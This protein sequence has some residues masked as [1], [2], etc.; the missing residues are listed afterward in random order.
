MII[1]QGVEGYDNR[2]F[3]SYTNKTEFIKIRK[4]LIN[5]TMKTEIYQHWIVKVSCALNCFLFS[6]IFV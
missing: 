2:E 3:N 6:M 5:Y 4:N 1:L